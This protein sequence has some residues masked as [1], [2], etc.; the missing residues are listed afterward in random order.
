MGLTEA[1]AFK[2]SS[3]GTAD[4]VNSA[5]TTD[6]V[7]D[8]AVTQAKIN[9][10]VIFT[11]VGTVITYAGSS[12]PTGYLKANG[13]T[14]P[15]GTGTVQGVTA[16]FSALYAVI[17]A[18]L[19]DL[20][21]EFIRGFDDGKGTDSGRAIRSSQTDQNKQHNHTATS[22][23]T[24]SGHRH[25]PENYSPNSNQS[26]GHGVAINDN[27]IGNY[28]GGSGTGLG[29]LGNRHF[30]E[31]TTTGISVSTTTA[32]DGGNESRP[33]NIALLMCIKF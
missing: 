32:N 4:I 19:P 29:P 26:N 11:P 5:I 31:N 28:G 10:A 9:N 1:S 14:I 25:L 20:R 17:G 33:R 13:D 21:G 16:D 30:L 6:K 3:I 12:A 15:N 2:D 7:A 22:T 27:V 18:T 23:V 24:D 8:G